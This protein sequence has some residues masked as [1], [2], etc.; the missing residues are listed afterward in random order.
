MSIR[1]MTAATTAAL[2][3]VTVFS[4][5]P[6]ALHADGLRTKEG[7]LLPKALQEALKGGGEPDA[8]ALAETEN[9]KL[10]A[11]GYDVVKI[12]GQEVSAGL[13]SDIWVLDCINNADFQ[14][15]ETSGASNFFPEAAEAFGRAAESLKG[16][17]RQVALYKRAVA[18]AQLDDVDQLLP[19]IETLVAEFPKS[20]YLGE[21]LTRKS[22]GLLAKGD[23]AGSQAAL[24]AI[25]S[26][27]GM[28]KR[29]LYAAEL[30]KVQ[31][32]MASNAGKDKA[33]LAEAE[34]AFRALSDRM[35]RESVARE[36]V[37]PIRLRALVGVGRMLVFQ[38]K[39]AEAKP[40]LQQ[41]I[42]APG[43]S[44][45]QAMLAGAYTALGHV[46]F[47]EASATQAAAG[48]DQEARKR[49]MSQLESAVLAYLRVTELYGEAAERSDLYDARVNAARAF[50]AI[51]GLSNDADCE[52]GRSANNYYV[53]AFKML[54]AGTE[55][56]QVGRELQALKA[57]LDKSCNKP[58]PKPQ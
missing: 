52:V 11:L 53:A 14:E 37:A 45:D 5:S 47:A 20:Y 57:R 32:F 6:A 21:L 41:V 8:T 56:N 7:K 51:F 50:G 42:D 43:S 55:R 44:G 46:L 13:V 3:L 29:D 33:K 22:R 30:A 2:A 49:A 16:A 39:L 48:S 15:G 18:I 9:A 1:L 36:E 4:G 31:L 34:A 35:E 23:S 25:I 28:N 26:A 58:A 27:S 24:D 17:A 40:F 19:A 10:Q 38:G 54:P 12:A